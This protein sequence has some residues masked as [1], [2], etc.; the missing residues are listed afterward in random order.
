MINRVCA[1]IITYNVKENIINVVNAIK[2][3]VSEVLLVDNGSDKSTLEILSDLKNTNNNVSLI[4]NNKNLG[5]AKAIN[6]GIKFATKKDFNWIL[7]LDHDTICEKDMIKKMFNVFNICNEK[8]SV[9][10]ISPR[11]FETTKKN[12][13]TKKNNGMFNYV[14]ECIQ[15]GSLIKISTIHKIG[16]FNEDL[17]IYHV[18]FEFCERIIN[19]GM[20]IL[21]C[22]NTTIYHEEGYKIPKNILGRKIF[23]NNY[24]C[25]AIYYI[26]RNTIYMSKK[27]N[28]FY[29]KRILKDFIHI[30]LFDKDRNNK[31][32]YLFYGIKDAFNNKYGKFED[33]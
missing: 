4:L 8:N 29:S 9:A 19:A 30:S 5:I 11:V 28:I 32:K 10:M 15:S 31:L 13:I 23:Y 20:K 27:Y 33:M 16:L 12:Y 6:K 3:Q 26:T 1:I 21:Q 17:F 24:S 22:N 25:L 18:D 14:R 7:T 2:G